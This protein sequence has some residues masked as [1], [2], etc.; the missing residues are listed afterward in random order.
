MSIVELVESGRWD[1]EYE[2]GSKM[3]TYEFSPDQI[4]LIV[5]EIK[6]LQEIEFMYEGLQK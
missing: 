2:N 1:Y 6:R 4:K 5:N 3:T